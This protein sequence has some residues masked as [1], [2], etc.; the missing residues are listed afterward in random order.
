MAGP[1][2]RTVADRQTSIQIQTSAYGICVP[3]VYGTNRIGGNLVWFGNFT[4]I[5]ATQK[6]GG[7]GGSSTTTT[8]TYRAA[9]ILALAEGTITGI[10]SVW[11]DKDKTT[12]AALGL[13]VFNGS[14]T[15]APW[16]FLTGYATPAN[17]DYDTSF[18]YLGSPT[19]VDQAI[20][21]SGTAYLAA[22]AYELGDSATIPNHSFEVQGKLIFAGGN[23]ALPS[24]VIN[25]VLT[26]QRYGVGFPA[27]NVDASTSYATY[28]QAAGLFV[29]PAYTQARPASD[30]IQELCDATNAA[31]VWSGGLLKII[32][33]GDTAITGNGATYTPNL[34]PLFDLT[35]DDF[36]DIDGGPIII[37]RKTPAD[38]YNRMSV[39]FRNRAN[40]YNQEVV[41]A[42]DQ[43]AIERYG[44]KV[45][46]TI[47]CDFICETAVA[48]Q[49]VQL[50]LQ[51]QLY[52]R[53]EYEFELGARFAMLEPMDI[54][55][56]TDPGL[57]MN[58]VPVRLI[59]I[60]ETDNG[61]RCVAED[62]P[63][64]VAA[65]ATYT[66]DNGLRWQNTT[67]IPAGNCAAPVI[68]EMPPD[69]VTTGL[70]VAI[71]CGGQPNDRMYGGCRV[72]LSLDGVNYKDQGV[73]VGKSRYGTTTATLPAA[74]AGIDG[75]STLAVSLRSGGQMLSGSAADLAKKTTLINVGGEYLA[76]QTATLTGTNAYS[77]TTLNRG[78]Y[79]TASG[80]KGSG[81]TWVRVDDGVLV[82]SDLDLSMIG[83]TVYIKVCSFNVYG[84][85]EQSLASVSAYTYT[86]TGNMKALES[87]ADLAN[88]I[89]GQGDLAT[90]NRAALPFGSNLLINTEF[91]LT[92]PTHYS[93]N[94]PVAWQPGWFGN[95]TN[96]GSVT[97]N[98]RRVALRDGS[99]AI[100]RDVTGA[101]NGTAF[102]CA[103]SYPPGNAFA[104]YGIPVLP[105]ERIVASALL[106]Y[107]G[108]QNAGVTIFFYDENYAYVDE[109]GGSSVTAN[110]GAA[111]YNT[112]TRSSLT[113]ASHAVTVPADGTGGGTGRRRWAT[114]GTR[115]F[116]T[117]SPVNPRAV[118]AAPFLAKVPVNQTAIPAYSPG[119]AD[120]QAS[121]GAITGNSL[122]STSFGTLSDADIR[123]IMGT[124]AGITGQAA[125]ATYT[126]FTPA[127]VTN[128]GANLLFN[129][130]FNIGTL[131]YV[132]NGWAGP[133]K[134]GGDVGAWF[135][136]CT[137]NDQ[138]LY[139][140]DVTKTPVF[141]NNT[142]TFQVYA[143][144]NGSSTGNDR[145]VFYVDWH[146]SAGA[147]ISS[148]AGQFIT[149]NVGYAVY[150][151][152]VTSP[153]GAAFARCVM[154]SNKIALGGGTIWTSKWKLEFGG[155]RTP[156]TDEA[157][158][159]ALYQSGQTIDSLKPAEANANV[160]ETRTAAAIA[161]QAWAATNG[162]QAAVDNNF[163]SGFANQAIDSE[164]TLGNKSWT[165]AYASAGTWGWN[166]F[167]ALTSKRF[168]E[169]STSS[170]PAGTGVN[171]GQDTACGVPV[172]EGDRLE[173]SGIVSTG[174]MSSASLFVGY[175]SAAGTYIGGNSVASEV[176]DTRIGGFVTVPSGLGIGIA[177]LMVVCTVATSGAAVV[178]LAQPFI[179]RC[180]QGQ[181]VLSPYQPGPPVQR[182]ADVT[183]QNVA[184]GFLG[185]GVGATANSLSELDP[186]AAALLSSLSASSTYVA[187][188]GSSFQM[189]LTAGQTVSLN[190]RVQVLAGG[191]SSGSVQ[192]LLQ[193]RPAGGSW[194]NFATGGLGS[195][196]ATEPGF[197]TAA[198]TFTNSTGVTGV[199][200]FR[201]DVSITPGSA[202]GGVDV[203]RSYI[204]I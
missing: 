120:R 10:G 89:V 37:T 79:G 36:I 99:F 166:Y 193:A 39:Q 204:R 157:T 186:S 40:Q 24:A 65:A 115:F 196:T 82:M 153:P 159:G 180:S 146:N 17:F 62:L 112:L 187:A 125:W 176:F 23:D 48:K 109:Y 141:A 142:Y 195:V 156:W 73:I 140:A 8:Y 9:A 143:A 80:A 66:H 155:A 29:S 57:A 91:A 126:G 69:Q 63:I 98:D 160:T 59:E 133:G 173:L 103:G 121:Y 152:T 168:I 148:S 130:S 189:V 70:A 50:A 139:S 114:L 192:C 78:L 154:N 110:I 26:A 164:F 74:A 197:S 150:S 161:G 3:V 85:A 100:A 169:R 171:I 162:S 181:T 32:P 44:L 68:F 131:G 184:V 77:L 18:G 53:N 33:Y 67:A 101:P 128:P 113:Q 129:S 14:D 170:V 76:Y 90:T 28:C 174:N 15:Q 203:Y 104:R 179:R 167:T 106:G 27:A 183:G 49:V 42:E 87:P 107:Q 199:F 198:G 118:I 190:G 163:V 84:A 182:G 54:V 147:F 7:K 188:I 194:S 72:W 96:L 105:G 122:V 88:A 45:A 172:I 93:G 35:D 25:D 95:S 13:S 41:S 92:E 34:T 94:M 12:L 2:S 22:S 111:A 6:T 71:A 134:S 175:F 145:P 102:D 132:V 185:Q 58:R 119:Q 97:F 31:P 43:D 151:V 83:Q 64:G 177:K 86:I 158:N 127:Q 56:L 136:A 149:M 81:T 4:P 138:F 11:K 75:T 124:A 19:F 38:A 46:S 165:E 201:V 52:K 116:I 191:S 16:S 135:M 51:R 178:R 21:Y 108:C 61:Y 200:E 144:A 55:T 1:S 137:T 60:E 117:G 47:T 123:T 30:V 20:N 202:G 5:S